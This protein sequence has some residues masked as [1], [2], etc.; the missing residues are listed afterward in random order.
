MNRAQAILT[1]ATLIAAMCVQAQADSLVVSQVDSKDNIIDMFP[2]P[3]LAQSYYD[4]GGTYTLYSQ[5]STDNKSMSY[6]VF[7]LSAYKGTHTITDMSFSYVVNRTNTT[8]ASLNLL[9]VAADW[10]ED[11]LTW[12]NS[13][14]YGH[15]L[16]EYGWTAG[17]TEWTGTGVMDMAANGPEVM[18]ETMISNAVTGYGSDTYAQLL[19]AMNADADG[20]LVFG[21]YGS[22]GGSYWR[23]IISRHDPVEANRPTLTVT[24]AEIVAYQ[25]G[26]ANGDG[27][28]NLA[29][30]QILGDNWQST[31]ASWAE[32]D[33]TG[34]NTVNLADLQ[35]I[36]DN[37]G[38]G[39]SPDV[40]FDEALAGVVIPE[41]ASL[42]LWGVIV[43]LLL[44]HRR[45]G[46]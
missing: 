43:P 19:D 24:L 29:D 6:M 34:D 17:A 36:G 30:L 12:N 10:D 25:P 42:A 23:H 7:D 2:A 32:A 3:D 13:T 37:W 38:F 40:S 9:N 22:V 11:T 1:A 44:R 45:H 16:S 14:A 33:F 46:D 31:T 4:R 5:N 8:N 27:M 39:V 21:M 20:I 35:I 41:P 15:T 26:D 28:V 18:D